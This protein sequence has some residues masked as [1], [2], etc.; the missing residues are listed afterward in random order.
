MS[1]FSCISHLDSFKETLNQVYFQLEDLLGGEAPGVA[2]SAVVY[3]GLDVLA[4]VE[5]SLLEVVVEGKAR[6]TV[7]VESDM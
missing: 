5:L 1:S 4:D 2:L 3:P 7:P 6:R